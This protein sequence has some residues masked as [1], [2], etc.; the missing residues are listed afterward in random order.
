M[1]TLLFI[2]FIAIGS[3]SG[4]VPNSPNTNNPLKAVNKSPLSNILTIIEE[5]NF[6]MDKHDADSHMNNIIYNTVNENLTITAKRNISFL[7][8]INPDGKIDFQLPVFSESVTIDLDDLESGDWSLQIMIDND[9]VIPA[10]FS[11]I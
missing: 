5:I 8:L 7:Q 9:T 10:T 2:F 6:Q 4:L 1:K 11:K 3:T